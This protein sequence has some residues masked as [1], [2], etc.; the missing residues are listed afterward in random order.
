MSRPGWFVEIIKAFFP[1]SGKWGVV[2]KIPLVGSALKRLMFDG[3]NMFV[4]PFDETVQPGDPPQDDQV[5]VLPSEVA[6]HFIDQAGEHWIMDNCLCRDSLTC[7]DYPIDLGC[8]FLGEAAKGINPKLGR[9][10]TAEQARAH[11]LRARQAGLVHTVGKSKLDTFWLGT[12]PGDRLMTICNCCPCC[13]ILRIAPHTRPSIRSSY[14]RMPGISIQ[15]TDDCTGCG[16]CT[17]GICFVNARTMVDDRP[18]TS[19]DCLGCGRCV[20]LCPEDAIRV[21]VENVDYVSETI[22]LLTKDVDVS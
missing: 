12:G 1:R 15:L 4:L 22:D 8:I 21:C 20:N 6:L 13:C 9:R 11:L 19:D 14:H 17:E 16:Q 2:T 5:M 3:D 7:K 10:V 18:V